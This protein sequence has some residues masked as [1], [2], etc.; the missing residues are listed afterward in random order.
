MTL[1]KITYRISRS[2]D[3]LLEEFFIILEILFWR[4]VTLAVREIGH[5]IL[6]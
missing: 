3:L 2:T 1:Y 4:E 5:R 6:T